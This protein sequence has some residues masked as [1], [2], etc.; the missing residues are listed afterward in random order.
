MRRFVA[1]LAD[2]M[3]AGH[4]T[5][6]GPASFLQRVQDAVRVDARTLRFCHDRLSSLLKALEVVDTDELGPLQLVADFGTLLGT[7]QRGFAVIME[8][9]DE[10]TPHIP[11]PVLQLSCLDASLAMRPVFSRFQSVV[12]T[13]GTLSPMA[14][15]PKILGVTP[16][17]TLALN[18]TLAR[19]CVCPVVVTRGADQV[20][21]KGGGGGEAG[22][23][24]SAW[25]LGGALEHKPCARSVLLS[26]KPHTLL[27]TIKTTI[28]KKN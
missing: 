22:A 15:Y 10:R 23:A 1:H 17:S 18:M 24:G 25:C 5:E 20:C 21:W 2:A 7:Y 26:T 11:D 12:V 9:Y 13:S 14:L 8:P 3:R 28:P 4:V 27:Q 16:T 19:E 6:E